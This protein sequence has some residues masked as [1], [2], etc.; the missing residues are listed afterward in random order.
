VV[1][2]TKASATAF[3]KSIVC[4]F[5]V[6]NQVI[7]DNGTQFT[8]QYFQ[9]YC[10]DIGIQLCFA[11]VVHPRSNGQVERANAEILR[12]LKIRTYCDL[13]KHGAK[14]VDQ[15]QSMLWGNWTIPNR[16]TGETPF[17]LVYGAE[18]C[19]PPEI[20]MG[21]LRVQAFDEDLQEQQRRQDVDFVDERRWRAVVR[22][23]RYNQ[24]LRRYHQRFMH[25]RELRVGDLVLRRILN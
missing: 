9:E 6:P 18:A 24:A 3:L 8:S 21:S 11:S 10:E 2:I 17:F 1:N 12:G 4:P 19:L 16:A 25:S 20:I 14:W 13:E 5:G 7:T 23:A 22:N 15:L